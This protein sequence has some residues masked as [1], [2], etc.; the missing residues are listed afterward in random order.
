MAQREAETLREQLSS[1]NKSLQLAT[2]I[3]K[4]PDVVRE[5][6]YWLLQVSDIPALQLLQFMPT[7]IKTAVWSHILTKRE[8][9]SCG[10]V[11]GFSFWGGW[12][13]EETTGRTEVAWLCGDPSLPGPGGQHNSQKWFHMAESI[14][15][16]EIEAAREPRWPSACACRCGAPSWGDPELPAHSASPYS[17]SGLS[18]KLEINLILLQFSLGLSKL[19]IT[20]INPWEIEK[21]PCTPARCLLCVVLNK[22]KAADGTCRH[23]GLFQGSSWP[24]VSRYHRWATRLFWFLFAKGEIGVFKCKYAIKWNLVYF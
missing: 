2:Q 1:A 7:A 4:A 22:A 12:W 18:E 20:P 15:R 11:V 19:R 5:N 14:S 24:W 9:C 8:W 17:V 6:I 13:L 23:R 16:G 3:Q 10:I 21:I